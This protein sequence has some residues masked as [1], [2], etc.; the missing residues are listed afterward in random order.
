MNSTSGGLLRGQLVYVC[1]CS[2]TSDILLL[3]AKMQRK[4]SVSCTAPV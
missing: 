3:C 4:H 1:M 2:C